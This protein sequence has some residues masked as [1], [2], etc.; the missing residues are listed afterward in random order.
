MIRMLLQREV[1][2]FNLILQNILSVDG[3]QIIINSIQIIPIVN[4]GF[5]SGYILWT[6]TCT[7]TAARI[8]PTARRKAS[9]AWRASLPRT[10]RPPSA[11]L[12]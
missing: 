3:P 1:V 2:V 7:A 12:R 8:F 5:V 9:F 4:K 11:R 10:A 6:F